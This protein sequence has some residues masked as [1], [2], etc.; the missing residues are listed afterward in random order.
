M[1]APHFENANLVDRPDAS[2][3]KD[4]VAS[5]RKNVGCQLFVVDAKFGG[6]NA[7][8]DCPALAGL[9]KIGLLECPQLQL[10]H[11]QTALRRR[12]I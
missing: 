11:F 3:S 12:A 5:R 6:R 7:Q 9:E 10:R 2:S 8:C 4:A 1:T